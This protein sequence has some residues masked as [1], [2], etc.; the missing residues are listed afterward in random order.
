[1]AQLSLGQPR[2]LGRRFGGAGAPR[3]DR[4]QLVQQLTLAHAPAR[5]LGLEGAD[6]PSELGEQVAELRGQALRL[7]EMVVAARSREPAL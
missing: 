5:D 1:L 6:V 4:G 7:L 3:P 2:L